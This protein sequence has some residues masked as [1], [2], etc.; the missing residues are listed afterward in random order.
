MALLCWKSSV[1]PHFDKEVYLVF[2]N[3]TSFLALTTSTHF[4]LLVLR[5]CLQFLKQVTGLFSLLPVPFSMLFYLPEMAFS[6]AG[7]QHQD[8]E[9]L[10]YRLP[11]SKIVDK[12]KMILIINPLY[13]THFLSRNL[14]Y[15]LPVYWNFTVCALLQ[16]LCSFTVLVTWW[17]FSIW[18]FKLFNSG[19][20]SWI[21]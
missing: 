5:R 7:H 1:A 6:G 2:D 18:N 17:I 8:F 21:I 16:S 15:S 12:S 20:F 3:L 11:A 4:N 9:G 19:K 10:L 13:V 14:E